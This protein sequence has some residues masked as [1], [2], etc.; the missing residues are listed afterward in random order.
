MAVCS[1]L[2]PEGGKSLLYQQLEQQY[3]PDKAAQIWSFT[4]SDEFANRHG[5]WQK[6]P[7]DI[8]LAGG[9]PTFDWVKDRLGLPD[10]IGSVKEPEPA[11]PRPVVPVNLEGDAKMTAS[12]A[13]RPSEEEMRGRVR[14]LYQKALGD[15]GSQ[16][17]LDYQDIGANPYK[18]G[19]TPKEIGN[20]L[21]SERIP[22]NISF[23][24]TMAK[25]I[26]NSGRRIKA[27]FESSYVPELI[28]RDEKAL[29]ENLMNILVP[30]MDASG[31]PQGFF[32]PQQQQEVVD[33]IIHATKTGL[34]QDPN[35]KANAF[36]S[37]FYKMQ[38]KALQ[39]QQTGE[40]P[41]MQQNL[42]FIYNQ[43]ERFAQQALKQLEDYGIKA[44]AQATAR[45]LDAVR[46][47]KPLGEMDK[48]AFSS[49]SPAITSEE[50]G[51]DGEITEASGRGLRDW[52]DVSFEIDPKDTAS[53]R[54]KMMIATLPEMDR[55]LYPMGKEGDDLSL[56]IDV[57]GNLIDTLNNWKKTDPIGLQRFVMQANRRPIW[58]KDEASTKQVTDFLQ[59]QYPMI[60]HTNFIG[61]RKLV[62][63]ESTFQELMERLAG[64]PADFNGYT[65]T[66]MDSGR[67]NLQ[68]LSQMLRGLDPSIQNEFTKVMSKQ[69]QQF[70]MV[71][72][73]RTRGEDGQEQFTLNPINANRYSQQQSLINYWQQEQKLSEM[74]KIN[75][76]GDRVL[77]VARARDRW[78]PTLKKMQTITDWSEETGAG[79]INFA[80]KSMQNIL[81][82]SGIDMTDPMMDYLFK[83]IPSLVK[84]KFPPSLPAQFGVDA[85]G[86]PTGIFSAFIMRSAGMANTEDADQDINQALSRAELYNPLYAERKAMGVLATVAARFTPTIHSDNHRNSK[87]KNVWDYGMHTKLSHLF[88]DMTLNF[89]KFKAT[90]DQVDV[91]KFNWLLNTISANRAHLD[92]IKLSYLDGLKPTW[93]TSGTTRGDMSDR[94]QMLMSLSLFQNGG[95]GFN[96]I[97]KVH[98]LSL[99]H[100]DKTTTPI[101]MNMPRV[102]VGKERDIPVSLVGTTGSTMYNVFRSEYAR[103]IN[104]SD[105]NFNDA[106]Y[107][108]GK[109]LFYFLPQFNYDN[110]KDM[111]KE[112]KLSQSEM[113]LIWMN[114]ERTLTSHINTEQELPVINKI[115]QQH[116][117][118]ITQ[119]TIR[120]WSEN[121]I[122]DIEGKKHMFD[123]AYVKKILTR[124]GYNKKKGAW[125]DT[126]GREADPATIFS[127]T[128]HV[129]AKDYVVNHF[130]MNTTMDQVFYGDPAQNFKGKEGAHD[131][132]NVDATMKEHA[133]RLAKDIAPGQDPIWRPDQKQYTTVTL[134]DI[135]TSE[136][137]LKDFSK[138]LGE[139]YEKTEG[140]DAQELTTTQEHLDVGYAMGLIRKNVYDEMTAIIKKAGPGGYYEFTQPEHL[141]VVLQPMKP[142]FSKART[143]VNGAMLEDYVK[144]S[145][146]PLYPP[147]TSGQEMDGLRQMMEKGNIQRANFES[148]KK[149]GV[150]TSPLK[151]FTPDGKFTPPQD[152]DIQSAAQV[153]DRGG[154]RIQQEVPYD[155]DKEKIRTVS[156]MN[157]LITEG[158]QD[159]PDFNIG[160]VKMNGAQVREYKELIRKQMVAQQ[161]GEFLRK[162]GSREA[163]GT[164]DKN[165]VYDMLARE[166]QSKGYTINELQGL[167]S[168]ND[169]G[170]LKIPL[171]LNPAVDR[172]ESL[173]MAMNKDVVNV[174][175]P[176]KSFVQAA[177]VGF[178]FTREKN[179][180]A[181]QRSKIVWAKDYD[182][183][184]LKTLRKE[185]GVVKPAQVL[186]PFNMFDTDGTKLRLQDFTIADPS[187]R[188]VLD[189]TRIPPQ[190]RQFIGARIPNQGHNSMLPLEVVGFIPEN[191]GDLT[192]V[193]S[194]I[195]K[196]MGADFDV[197]KLYTYK[198]PYNVES[199][200]GKFDEARYT[201]IVPTPSL[202]AWD[203]GD[204]EGSQE[205][206]QAAQN[207]K[208]AAVAGDQRIG[209]H[210]E[211][212]NEV[213]DRVLPFFHQQLENAP[214]NTVLSTHS[215]VMKLMQQWDKEGRNTNYR[216]DPEAYNG[217]STQN[218]DVV[219]FKGK[220]GTVWVVRHGQTVDNEQNNFRSGNT[221]L[222]DEGMAQ[223]HE[224]G[225]FIK[226]NV[227]GPIPQIISSDLPRTIHT[228]NIINEEL[229]TEPADRKFIT[230]VERSRDIREGQY[231]THKQ[232]QLPS[233]ELATI[234]DN[235]SLDIE[236]YDTQRSGMAEL[237]SKYFDTHWGV[238][239]H[240]DMT[241]KVLRPLDKSD[242]SDE[243]GVLAKKSQYNDNYYNVLNQLQDYQSGKDA[244][245]LV[246]L[247]SLAVTFNATIQNK[248]LHLYKEDIVPAEGGGYDIKQSDRF[249][250]VKDEH[251]G[252]PM[253]LYR[254]SGTGTSK[255]VKD[256]QN[257]DD[258]NIDSVRSKQDNHTT[259]QSAAVDNAKNRT[260]DNLNITT[261]TF[262][263]ASAM[264]QLET[265]DGKAINLKYVTR[266]LTQPVIKE[267]DK[268]M[269]TGNDSLSD[270]FNKDLKASVFNS[271]E[272]KYNTSPNIEKKAQ[273]IEFDPQTL[274]K[275]QRMKPGS[276]DYNAHQLAALQLFQQFDEVGERLGNL[277]GLFNQNT[278]GA[279]INILTSLDKA[280]KLT[281]V[282]QVPIANAHQIYG[283]DETGD[284]HKTEQGML[285][286]STVGQVN[287]LYTQLIP[288]NRMTATF[289]S[290]AS[291][292]GKPEGLSIEQ[293]RQVIKGIRSFT[294][295]SPDTWWTNAQTDRVRLLYGGEGVDSLG[296]RVADAKRTWGKDNYFLQRL[297]AKIGNTS[298][299][300]DYV[301][302]QA[303]SVGRIDE[304]Q[305]VRSWI[306]MLASDDAQVR[307][308][309]EDLLRYAFLTG[310]VQDANSFVK[311]VP[312]SYLT[313]TAFGKAMQERAGGIE[314]LDTNKDLQ[315]ILPGFI[316]QHFQHNPQMAAQIDQESL[317]KLVEV[318]GGKQLSVDYPE[319]FRLPERESQPFKDLGM[320]KYTDND[321][322]PLDYISYRS[323]AE[324]KWILYKSQVIGDG[325]YY[326]RIDTLGNQYTDEYNGGVP[327]GQ[328]SIFTE[329]R[330]LAD[331]V[332]TSPIDEI[333]K[334]KNESLGGYYDGVSPYD[335]L[336]IKEGGENEF[337]NAVTNIANNKEVDQHIRTTAFM[338][339]K[340][341]ESP[342]AKAARKII[343]ISPWKPNIK[344]E[345][346]KGVAG[347]SA[348][349]GTIRLNPTSYKTV[350]GAAEVVVHEMMH[351]HLQAL[352]VATGYDQRFHDMINKEDKSFRKEMLGRVEE[353]KNKYPEV[354]QSMKALD[355]IRYQALNALRGQ[356]GEQ[357]YQSAVS[358]Y[359]NP[360]RAKVS[361]DAS[362]A[363]GLSS[364]QEFTAHVLTNDPVMQHLDSI[365]TGKT[366]W[367]GKIWNK[368]KSIILNLARDSGYKYTDGSLLEEA[369]GHTLNLTNLSK[370]G[371]NVDITNSLTGGGPMT[372]GSEAEALEL[373]SLGRNTYSRKT[374]VSSDPLNFHINLSNESL[375][376]TSLETAVDKL[377]PKLRAQMEAAGRDISKAQEKEAQVKATIRYQDLKKDYNELTRTRDRD[378][379]VA[380]GDK[381]IKW[382]DQ[383]LGDPHTT[384]TNIHAAI[385]S[386][387]IWAGIGN[388]L[389]HDL[390]AVN[391]GRDP[392]LDKLQQDAIERRQVLINT[393][394]REVVVDALKHRIQLQPAD[395]G[396]NLK[397]IN[398]A[399]ANFLT[400]GRV[401]PKIAQGI[402]IMG[403]EAANNRDEE[404]SRDS[405]VL[406]S[407]HNSGQ[408]LK[409]FLQ[410][411]TW[412]LR[413]RLS[414]A[415][416]KYNRSIE[417]KRER[418]LDAVD[419]AQ[420]INDQTRARVR[421]KIWSEY[422]N[423]KRST[424]AFVD[425][426]AFYDLKDG[427]LK[428]TD[429]GYEKARQDLARQV[430]SEEYA[431]ELIQ[432]GQQ[433]FKD[434]ISSR[435]IAR[436]HFDATTELEDHE[437]TGDPA[438]DETARKKKVFDQ[439]NSWLTTNSPT[440]F[441]NRMEAAKKSKGVN[442]GDKWIVT[443]PKA[444]RKEF[445]DDKFDSI[446]KD[447]K[448]SATYKKLTDFQRELVSCL[449]ATERAKLDEN[450]LPF[451]STDTVNTLAS[452]VGK[453]RNWDSTLMNVLTATDAEAWAK[454]KPDEIPILYTYKPKYMDDDPSRQSQDIIR[455]MEIFSMMARHYKNMAPVLD[456]IN[457]AENIIQEVNRQRV[458]EETTG[459]IMRNLQ[460]SIK[461]FKD[462]LIFKKPR[463]LQGKVDSD[464]YSF[465]PAKQIRIQKTV[466]ELTRQRNE[467]EKTMEE[468]W[469]EGDFQ[470]DEEQTKIDKLN[471]QLDE[472]AGQARQ[473]YGSKAA[474][475]LINLNQMKVLSYNPFSALANF[476]F[477]S[478]S[479]SIH[480]NGRVDFD[481]PT[482][483]RAT[484]MLMNSVMKY[485]TFG[486]K[487]SPMSQKINA[488]M[489]RM[490]MM[491]DIVD[492][493]YGESNI[494]DLK[495]S[496]LL[497]AIHPY[498]WHK[499]SDFF[500]RG[501]MAVAMMLK[502]QVEVTDQATGEVKK[503]PLFDVLNQE[504]QWDAAKWGENK[505]WSSPEVSEQVAWNHFRDKAR[506]V[507]ILVFGNR[508]KN[509]PLLAR[510]SYLL[511]LVG[512]FRMSFFPEGLAQ[513]FLS[514]REDLDLGR[515]VKGRYRTYA[516]LGFF[517]SATLL[518]KQLLSA[519]P[520]V[521]IS[522]FEGAT[523]KQGA[524]IDEVDIENMRKNFA[525]L[526]WTVAMTA[527]IVAMKMLCE[528]DDKKKGH[529]AQVTGSAR[530]VLNMLTRNYQDLT[531]YSNPTTVDDVLG[532]LLP[533]SAVV[534]DTWRAMEATGHYLMNGNDHDKH[535]FDKWT[536][537]VTRAFP[538]LNLYPKT[539]YM[540]TRDVG[541]I[542]K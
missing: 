174:K 238:L 234:D 288:Y 211:T 375:A 443:A 314:Q 259:I 362:L 534:T 372:T 304:E 472:Y 157:T 517:T 88:Q 233:D 437:K 369:I 420:N 192:I 148:A 160:G 49:S 3:G 324:G 140:T 216:V 519:L 190:F 535:A 487:E 276:D 389:Y 281:K 116:V 484:G 455:T 272:N 125:M 278:N 7:G 399:E 334:L 435:D 194:A 66:L 244:K 384:A 71:L 122:V 335:K 108:K 320:E 328:R 482:L 454:L 540:L 79:N 33:T 69:Y 112:G 371:R 268:M 475:A 54:I 542:S 62:D 426:R 423:D 98:Y 91:A 5:D 15:P 505:E 130:L 392:R 398:L 256:G 202:R 43:R 143:P 126:S 205:T 199:R 538:I 137:Y 178:T 474:D 444:A 507:G 461:Y 536:K 223:A 56:P 370:P 279:G 189:E 42:S 87:G 206:T 226:N 20:L 198:R 531:L 499:S 156:Q 373:A 105:V 109:K 329:N 215:S 524:P 354:Y 448:K 169:N 356:W 28:G 298:D 299:A 470:T 283:S 464:I 13:N 511:R 322:V 196:Q 311:F 364:L 102:D 449:P 353:F 393:A 457:V 412:A 503:I 58:Y 510:K 138:M 8:P 52:T 217:K 131:Q 38:Q 99:T 355:D 293:Q 265:K 31:S 185:N 436:D 184:P 111:V 360:N 441:M 47:L 401:K 300:P 22:E 366:T 521:N 120:R 352:I 381:Q 77:D 14:D 163:E 182:G 218:A 48:D 368:F 509:S 333:M 345:T 50:V 533:A 477:S 193:P 452:M 292:A 504:G 367:L 267:Y 309:G 439:F 413:T 34:D 462:A 357:R 168:R 440:E 416:Y 383:V 181:E 410:D 414:P 264:A 139:A 303:S 132:A 400:L 73:N 402:S 64:T 427:S 382:I 170:D 349:D 297:D 525:G 301:Q 86:E 84:G 188:L 496:T 255:Y 145:S 422:W 254:L 83:N 541:A 442:Y 29:Q 388:L 453:I 231:L 394:A 359:A 407:L 153:L 44:D 46:N 45:V 342:E 273:A 331:R 446:M 85:K 164:I 465:N 516:D 147:L 236:H 197:D 201:N 68:Y 248:N 65:K 319:S 358:E 222:T 39:L 246:A 175:I 377:L 411:D 59:A 337:R 115:L 501:R 405:K 12:L 466:V 123:N 26:L 250:R 225:R 468:K 32:T 57:K 4:R 489:E 93:G 70:T 307:G 162:F 290:I 179:L 282:D 41:E 350:N 242:L 497:H 249:I 326:T 119:D 165:Q 532:N 94:E 530:L 9:E 67:P 166:A 518:C 230:G 183:S 473:I 476:S 348:L 75:E 208:D 463:E 478:I 19:Y 135:S 24:P 450:F 253:D 262:R 224:A 172:L 520:G 380:I 429:P 258:P 37:G 336:N 151:V 2:N 488:I 295:T 306:S 287:S 321:G 212:F 515:T 239:M 82:V 221:P 302:Y 529:A 417:D 391:T 107:D 386:A 340:M 296:K 522:P 30:K 251:T 280:N 506:K 451:V 277:Q 237:Q 146:Y 6:F 284:T 232:N 286:D 11:P 63:Y 419:Q 247:S 180:T 173:M 72:F 502:Q 513:R 403:R 245:M 204:L 176:G 458:N 117:R 498:Q 263:A 113:N 424:T 270:T 316:T 408:N 1:H 229:G 471:E 55:A 480:A 271:L 323:K 289:N 114:G 207:I 78:I 243:N 167:L 25:Y 428:S 447:P 92:N 23:H 121:G 526:A 51:K 240:P 158:I 459:P 330:A 310:G 396:Q 213:Q 53:S 361:A 390:E 106:K 95:N 343:S 118:D 325:I 61:M 96:K 425:S 308:L 128:V 10:M 60:P 274:L 494:P 438:A 257:P 159:I 305:N 327:G 219:P 104:Q 378:M 89:D 101:F 129:A 203:Q 363:Y 27:A 495:N 528:N 418:Q 315:Q 252:E 469:N 155:E 492:S 431:D 154:F 35:A 21:D 124:A 318:G 40:N 467:L 142:V 228:S 445:F 186:L 479:L 103:I 260:L 433:Q 210:G 80:K 152:N 144:S 141:A 387:G 317:K 385:N 187:G 527:S 485:Y 177:S 374:D 421:A 235:D 339:S 379:I 150:P 312:T 171:W 313:D 409:E 434:Y 261:N 275:A 294:Y 227:D 81:K 500:N 481:H 90:Y 539:K 209:T 161:L 241:E 36:V 491:G 486:A 537:K 100:S 220:H 195:T 490:G 430:G 432:K 344:F 395:F 365:P 347:S 512:Q 415:W 338:L 191:M 346:M 149:I 200:R 456:Q 17:E 269:K 404:I 266:L 110:M 376:P 136:S 508:D 127:T 341:T 214:H 74:M 351:S 291:I 523:N 332:V 97:P 493:Q 134:K 18:S 397:E 406:Q 460:D 76:A 16:Y 483:N 514:E 285:F 133:K